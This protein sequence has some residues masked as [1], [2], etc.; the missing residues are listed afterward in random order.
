MLAAAALRLRAMRL[1]V[2][3]NLARR[4]ALVPRAE[5]PGSIPTSDTPSCGETTSRR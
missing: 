5:C 4:E 2:I 1:I 3:Q